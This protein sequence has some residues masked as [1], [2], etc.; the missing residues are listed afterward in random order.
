MGAEIDYAALFG[1]DT[2]GAQEPETADPASQEAATGEQA[3]EPAAPAV[4]APDQMPEQLP[5]EQPPAAPQADPE[6][7]PEGSTQSPEERAKYAAARRK[8]E[9]QRDE[10]I[11]QAREQAM[12]DAR[13]YMNRVLAGSGLT[14]PYTK[15]PIRTVAEYEAFDKQRQ[16]ELQ[17]NF[18]R[19]NGLTQT[20]YQEFVNSLPEVQT[21]RTIQA[22]AEQ[23]LQTAKEQ[24]ARIKLDEQVKKIQ[25]F[26][27]TV[28]DLESLVQDPSYPEVYKLVQQGY[29]LDHAYKL[30]HFDQLMGQGTAAAQQQARNAAAGKAHLTATKSRG[31]GAATVPA[32]VMKLYKTMMPGATEEEIRRHYARSAREK[33]KG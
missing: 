3:Q 6:G 2:A 14:N 11:R 18:I 32:D 30:V 21:A 12:A 9:S 17:D 1:M 27:P 10:A 24:Q 20:Q 26:D 8:A 31:A 5:Q 22:Q 16:K 19:S 7:K 15:E 13:A 25:G 33:G 28:K 29:A 4:D 23:E